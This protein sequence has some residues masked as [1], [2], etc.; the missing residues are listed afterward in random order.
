MRPWQVKTLLT[1]LV[2]GFLLVDI[3]LFVELWDLAEPS[4]FYPEMLRAGVVIAG[5]G[6]LALWVG[7]G[8]EPIFMRLPRGLFL[9]CLVALTL[10]FG[11]WLTATQSLDADELVVPIFLFFYF[12][13][14]LA[15]FL[16]IRRLR[17]W[18]IINMTS[19]SASPE[20][21]VARYSLSRLFLWQTCTAVVLFAGAPFFRDSEI[22][23]T[24]AEVAGILKFAAIYGLL[25]LS[26]F[27]TLRITLSTEKILLSSI[28]AIVS[29][30]ITFLGMLYAIHLEQGTLASDDIWPILSLF[31][32]FHA[33]ILGSLLF[34]RTIGYRLVRD[35]GDGLVLP[36]L[37]L[38]E[39]KF[40]AKR[41]FAISLAVLLAVFTLFGLGVQ[42]GLIAQAQQVRTMYWY[43]LGIELVEYE[44]GRGDKFDF[45]QLQPVKPEALEILEENPQVT[46]V[47]FSGSEVYDQQLEYLNQLPNLKVLFLENTEIT[48]AGLKYLEE[49]QGLQKLYLRGS[50]V[51]PKGVQRL[52]QALPDCRIIY[53]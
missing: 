23:I 22:E 27:F 47:E 32:S 25:S 5:P 20:A 40:N 10:L 44:D 36:R 26:V 13:F 30:V 19:Q 4:T 28:F 7:F 12:G 48:D 46:C 41:R 33:A 16:I 49:I 52:Q 9:L 11:E 8:S 53:P 6:L 50:Q 35:K 39:K 29:V 51:S 31:I 42:Q 18:R 38:Q 24:F 17:K 45:Y 34:V 43:N 3:S 15:A 2:S 21:S 14:M 1:L 37:D